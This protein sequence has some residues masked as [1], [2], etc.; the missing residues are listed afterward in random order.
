MKDGIGKY[1]VII[2]VVIAVSILGAAFI[3]NKEMITGDRR[4]V[5]MDGSYTKSV[6]P[7]KVEV[8]FTILTNASNAQ[9]AQ[10]MNAELTDEIIDALEDRGYTKDDIE[11]VYY[12][13]RPRYEWSGGSQNLIG[14]EATHQIKVNDSDI[15]NAGSIVDIAV[16]NGANRVDYIDFGL[17]QE[18]E[19]EIRVESLAKASANAREKADGIAQGLGMKVKRVISVNEGN[20]Y[21][22]PYRFDY[23]MAMESSAGTAVKDVQIVSGNV[24]VSAYVS[25]VFELA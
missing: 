6:V 8:T 3:M 11:T 10:D 23:A 15:K 2:A 4:T 14:Y 21:Y 13:V 16:S 17:S 12:N 20:M 22:P 25:I 7:D 1:A 9:D 19:Q 5:T 18:K 24:E